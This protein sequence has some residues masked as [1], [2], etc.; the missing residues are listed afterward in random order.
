[1]PEDSFFVNVAAWPKNSLKRDA[2]A[3]L[4]ALEAQQPC[5]HWNVP[6]APK[7]ARLLGPEMLHLGYIPGWRP[8]A[9]LQGA[10]KNKVPLYW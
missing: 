1:M 10:R 6:V 4:P 8:A 2:S 5:N 3:L 7:A 9:R